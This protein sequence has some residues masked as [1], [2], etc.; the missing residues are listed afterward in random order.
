VTSAA[1]TGRSLAQPLPCSAPSG[2][3]GGGYR[4]GASSSRRCAGRAIADGWFTHLRRTR[5]PRGDGDLPAVRQD[6]GR[7][8][9]VPVGA[10]QRRTATRTVEAGHRT[11]PRDGDD[12]SAQTMERLSRADEHLEAL[13]KFR[14]VGWAGTKVIAGMTTSTGRLRRGSAAPAW[15]VCI[16]TSPPHGTAYM[17]TMIVDEFHL[18]VMPVLL[19][20]GLRL[21]EDTDLQRGRVPQ[22]KQSAGRSGADQPHIPRQPIAVMDVQVDGTAAPHDARI[23]RLRPRRAT[24]TDGRT[25]PRTTTS[26]TRTRITRSSTARAVDRLHSRRR[27]RADAGAGDRMLLAGTRHGALVGWGAPASGKV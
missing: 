16:P 8:T 26:S 18:D 25:G 7:P 9:K 6:A 15:T 3:M 5:R 23:R 17:D 27:T 14:P 19:G 1:G 2:W 22:G 12:G 13:R 20:G 10:I 11:F 24:C 4:P 21:F